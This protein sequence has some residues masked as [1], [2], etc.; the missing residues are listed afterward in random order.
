PIES[1]D[2]DDVA[3]AEL[4]HGVDEFLQADRFEADGFAFLFVAVFDR[5]AVLPDV[6]GD[7]VGFVEQSEQHGRVVFVAGGGALPEAHGVFVGRAVVVIIG[8][9]VG[10]FGGG[11]GDDAVNDPA[12]GF[13]GAAIGGQVV[14]AE[15]VVAL[16]GEADDVGVPVVQ[17]GVEQAKERLALGIP[18]QAGD[19]QSA[20]EHG[21][22]GGIE[23]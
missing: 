12:V 4:A 22:P 7:A 5:A 14:A 23:D 19:V 17:R 8:H 6:P 1:A 9:D 11:L 20:Q 21:I 15:P 3:R 10:T 16:D 13:V 18:F 2:D